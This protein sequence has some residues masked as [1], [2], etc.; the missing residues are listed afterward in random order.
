MQEEGGSHWIKREP[1]GEEGSEG[2][3]MYLGLEVE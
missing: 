3:A 2:G 1:A